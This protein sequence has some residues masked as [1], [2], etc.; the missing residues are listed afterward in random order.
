MGKDV[1]PI[2]NEHLR[3]LGDVDQLDV[4][5]YTAGGDT[6]TG[7]GL[8]RLTREFAGHVG[9]LVPARCHSAGTLFA[10]GANEIVMTRGATLSPI[11]PSVTGP[12]NPV[13]EI[14]A[15]Q[16]QVV[17]LSVE[18]VAGFQGLAQEEWGI[19]GEEALT[20]AFRSLAEKVHPIALGDVF[21]ARQQIELLARKLLESHRPRDNESVFRIIHTLTKGLGSHDYLISRTEAHEILGDQVVSA[22]SELET[23]LARLLEG[24]SDAMKLREPFDAGSEI[25][26]AAGS[27]PSSGGAPTAT[28]VLRQAFIESAF[29]SHV[30]EREVTLKS[31]QVQVAMGPQGP[32]VIPAIQQEVVRA[33]WRFYPPVSP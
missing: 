17:P 2:F 13:I 28:V 31:V 25:K 16:R 11:D 3:G 20:A 26:Q 29:G 33:G 9:A 21:R 23:H 8:A 32:Q 19:R 1:M 14:A 4:F 24:F 27:A 7:F 6:L 10:L 12:L 15:G 5:L 30:F 22:S 18:S